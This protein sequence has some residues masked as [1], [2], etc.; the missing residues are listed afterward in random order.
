MA[1]PEAMAAK[2]IANLKDNTGKTLEQWTALA[3]KAKL[4]KHGM[5]VKWLKTEH[6]LTHGYLTRWEE[7]LMVHH[8]ANGQL[9]PGNADRLAPVGRLRR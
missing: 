7:L 3:K 9:P 8:A 1:T 5:L 4:D 2:M 6:E